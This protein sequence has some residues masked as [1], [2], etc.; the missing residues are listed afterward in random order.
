MRHIA[1]TT[2]DQPREAM[3]ELAVELLERRRE[4]PGAPGRVRLVKPALIERETTRR[5]LPRSA[6]ARVA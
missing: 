3:G 4:R 5:P 1:L 2:V 6:S